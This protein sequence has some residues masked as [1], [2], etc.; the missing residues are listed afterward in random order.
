MRGP[1]KFYHRG[2]KLDNVFFFD[3]GRENPSTNINGSSS[4]L[5]RNAFSET[6]L[7]AFRWRIDNGPTLNAVL[8]GLRF[9]RGSG[10]VLLE[11]P[12]FL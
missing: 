6:P 11:N 7:M 8:V 1:R 5:Q 2:S 4:T 9:F 12:I 10:P 3:Q